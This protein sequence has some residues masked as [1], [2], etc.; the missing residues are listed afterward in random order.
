M[1]VDSSH[2]ADQPMARSPAVRARRRVVEVTALAGG[3]A[4]VMLAL[5]AVKQWLHPAFSA[6]D[7][8]IITVVFSSAVAVESVP[9]KGTSVTVAF[10][11]DP[12]RS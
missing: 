1:S 12:D 2:L 5:E 6:W 8:H 3:V 4:G 11:Y 7:S 10:P 9:G